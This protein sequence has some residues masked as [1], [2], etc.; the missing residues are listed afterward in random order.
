MLLPLAQAAAV[1]MDSS[2][3]EVDASA[4]PWLAVAPDPAAAI[5]CVDVPVTGRADMAATGRAEDRIAAATKDATKWTRVEALRS[6]M[7]ERERWKSERRRQV[8]GAS[9]MKKVD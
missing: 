6:V 1:Y 8:H 4:T 7:L 2:L 5:D 3:R 9:N